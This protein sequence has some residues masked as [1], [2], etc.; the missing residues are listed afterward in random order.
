MISTG[1]FA[2]YSKALADVALE[3]G[4]EGDVGRDLSTYRE[5]FAAV[6]DLLVIFDSP[7]VQRETKERILEQLLGKYQVGV[8]TAKEGVDVTA[9][10]ASAPRAKSKRFMGQHSVQ[11]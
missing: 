11:N 6:P 3:T 7:A 10:Q 5:I 4:Q 1:I 8:T 2:R 9:R